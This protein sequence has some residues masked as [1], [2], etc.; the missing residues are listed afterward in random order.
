MFKIYEPI[1]DKSD[2]KTW[3]LKLKV[4]GFRPSDSE[5][6]DKASVTQTLW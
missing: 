5:T 4:R 3:T 2:K 6:Y 1:S